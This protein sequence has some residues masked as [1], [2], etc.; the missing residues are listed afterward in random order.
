MFKLQSD[1]KHRANDVDN[2]VD[3]DYTGFVFELL[4]DC[5]NGRINEIIVMHTPEQALAHINDFYFYNQNSGL[6]AMTSPEALNKIL[7][8]IQQDGKAPTREDFLFKTTQ[9]LRLRLGA[10]RWRQLTKDIANALAIASP[11]EQGK[12]DG[13]SNLNR[14]IN[15][16]RLEQFQADYWLVTYALLAIYPRLPTLIA[17]AISDFNSAQAKAH[18]GAHGR[19]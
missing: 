16:P 15:T 11:P 9:Y 3:V 10:D 6:S 18:R 19:Q 8:L 5:V 14:S 17:N 2:D 7:H 13:L 12:H 1:L 4:E